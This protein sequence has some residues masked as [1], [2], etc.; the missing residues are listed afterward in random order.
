MTTT[1]EKERRAA[2][3]KAGPKAA[4]VAKAAKGPKK[5]ADRLAAIKA[6]AATLDTGNSGLFT[7][8]GKPQVAALEAAEGMGWRPSAKDRDEAWKQMQTEAT[9]A[10]EDGAKDSGDGSG[11]ET[12][13]SAG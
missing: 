9:E 5:K 6:A 13:P 4:T 8:D 7:D 10:G 3:K 11:D 1:A 2:R 12:A